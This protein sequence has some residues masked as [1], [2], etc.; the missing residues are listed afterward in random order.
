[1]GYGGMLVWTIN[2]VIDGRPH[3]RNELRRTKREKTRH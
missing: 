1:M 2:S 3:T